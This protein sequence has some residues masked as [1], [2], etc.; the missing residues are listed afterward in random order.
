MYTLEELNSKII[1]IFR[2]ERSGSTWFV[3]SLH[4]LLKRSGIFLDNSVGNAKYKEIYDYCNSTNQSTDLFKYILSTHN[5]KNLENLVDYT[6][7]IVF[8][9]TRKNKTEQFISHYIMARTGIPNVYSHNEVNNLPKLEPVTLYREQIYT[10]IDKMRDKENLW[11]QYTS[12][13][14]NETVYYEDLLEFW[15]S[16]IIPI[17]LSMQNISEPQ[18]SPKDRKIKTIPVKLPYNKKELIINYDEVDTILRQEL[19]PY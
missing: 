10:Y 17:K 9:V 19:G 18:K 7:P 3:R 15:E 12:D 13:Y 14:E 2:E 4:N 8:R 16:S 5:F 6:N 1:W 11:K